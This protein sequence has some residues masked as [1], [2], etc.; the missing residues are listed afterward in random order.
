MLNVNQTSQLLTQMENS[1]RIVCVCHDNPDGDAIGSM[2][3]LSLILKENFKDKEIISAC[4]DQAPASFKFIKSVE[5]IKNIINPQ[6]GDLFFFL[7]SAEPKLISFH[8]IHPYLFSPETTKEKGISTI[9][10]D[11]HPSGSEF[12]QINFLDPEA[13]STCEIVVDMMDAVDFK[14]NTDAATALLTGIYTD[15]GSM[16][17]SNTSQRVYRTSA[18]LLRAGADQKKIVENVYRTTK[19]SSLR[20]WGKVLEKIS[21]TPEGGAVSAV[22]MSDFRST[23]SHFSELNG[24]IDYLNSIPGMKF[25]M[26][27]SERDGKVKGSL[28]TLREDVDVSA[29]AQKFSGGGH[30]KAAGFS[31]DGTLEE[32]RRWK[33]VP[34]DASTRTSTNSG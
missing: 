31:L 25:S 8:E 20:L 14:I 7:D 9:K 5:S 33:V 4:K 32:E 19:P 6:S 13:A 12:G 27:L 1:K 28:R 2:L 30:K 26:I 17:H 21:I 15:T 24:A 18:R 29:M 11:H 34:G 3:G 10:A 23:G 16:M 22:T